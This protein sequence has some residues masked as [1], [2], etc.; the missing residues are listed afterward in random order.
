MSEKKDI[1]CVIIGDSGVGKTSLLITRTTKVF[2]EDVP[3]LL[4]FAKTTLRSAGCEYTLHL[5]DTTWEQGYTRLCSLWYP[6]T[7]VFLFC[8]S[9]DSW[10]SL[11]RVRERWYP[12]ILHM[13]PD[14]PSV[15]VG[16]KTDL[17]D[18]S[19]M[20]RELESRKLGPVKFHDAAKLAR[21]LRCAYV[22]CSAREGQGVDKV[23]EEALAAALLPRK[24]AKKSRCRIL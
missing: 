12:E 20:V 23:F 16:L 13:C 4:E 17:R 3:K 22:E 2:P 18:D 14:V 9:I 5:W 11:D 10:D 6:H 8:F 21:D 15:L 19:D 1:K 7:D 24:V